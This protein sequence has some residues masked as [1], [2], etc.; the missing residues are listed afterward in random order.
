M[1]ADGIIFPI[2]AVLL[3]KTATYDRMLETFSRRV[4]PHLEYD[5]SAD[6]EVAVRGET[7]DFYRYIDFTPI[8]EDFQRLIVET[9]RTEWRYELDY[10]ADYD[11]MRREMREIVD[12]PEKKANQFILF[13]QNNCGHLSAAKR[14]LFAELT[15]DEITQLERIVTN[16]TPDCTRA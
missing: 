16:S 6:G 2:S 1:P 14:P 9:I 12:L 15:D 3:K 11:R 13:V 8:V 10:L 4:M 7:S 5:V